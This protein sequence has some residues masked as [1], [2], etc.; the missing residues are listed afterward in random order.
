SPLLRRLP[1]LFVWWDPRFK[2][3][4]PGPTHA[5]PRFSSRAL[6]TVFEFAREVQQRTFRENALPRAR[7]LVVVTNANDPAVDNRA[8]QSLVD[9][10][11][12]NGAA[13]VEA[14]EFDASLRLLHDLIDEQQVGQRTDV[15]YPV[16]TRLIAGQTY[17]G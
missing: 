9:R 11:R 4:L 2:A 16:L 8:T 5:Y 12:T 13:N 6:T 15:V 7:S 17:R 1:N 10:W 14:F 3:N